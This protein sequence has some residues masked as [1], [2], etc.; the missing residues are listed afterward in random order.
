[1]SERYC[2]AM[3]RVYLILRICC[4][5]SRVQWCT[6]SSSN[7]CHISTHPRRDASPPP[8]SLLGIPVQKIEMESM[9]ERNCNTKGLHYSAALLCVECSAAHL[10][11]QT[12][13]LL[14][15][16]GVPS[17]LVRKVYWLSTGQLSTSKLAIEM[18]G[19]CSRWQVQLPNLPGH[20]ETSQGRL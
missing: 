16:T 1:M 2:D 11:V 4:V 5:Q 9:S 12:Q 8:P 14:M 3:Q 19:C 15:E 20:S 13:H 7:I 18:T 17:V 10:P 6:L